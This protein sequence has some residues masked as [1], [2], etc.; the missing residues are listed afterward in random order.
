[1]YPTKRLSPLTLI[2]LFLLVLL[3][4]CSTTPS[5]VRYQVVP[6]PA[7]QPED[8]EKLL[9]AANE[10]VQYNAI[11][12]LIAHATTYAKILDAGLDRGKEGDAE[13]VGKYDNAKHVYQQSRESSRA[14]TR[15]SRSL[16]SSSRGNLVGTSIKVTKEKNSSNSCHD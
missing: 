6:I 7:Y 5:V 16:A 14:A 15:I 13:M 4:G 9:N 12:N 3:S 2:P 11:S 10:E 8:Y 1:M